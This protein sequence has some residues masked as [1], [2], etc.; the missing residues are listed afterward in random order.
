MLHNVLFMVAWNYSVF[1][2]F[3]SLAESEL[4][5]LLILL[6]FILIGIGLV[7]YSL[8]NLFNKTTIMVNK[9][10]LKIQH[11]PSSSSCNKI[12]KSN[13]IVR[14]TIQSKCTKYGKKIACYNIHAHFNNA[15]TIVLVSGLSKKENAW[16]IGKE[17]E[18]FL[19]TQSKEKSTAQNMMA[20]I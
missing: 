1:A 11:E 9:N 4:I 5:P 16:R 2:A 7:Y 3:R 19:E 15:Q 17:I 10:M 12:L 20:S 8:I 13:E 14:L 6:P 18:C